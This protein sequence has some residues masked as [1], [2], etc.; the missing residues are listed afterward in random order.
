M[1]YCPVQSQQEACSLYGWSGIWCVLRL[2]SLGDPDVHMFLSL[3][4]Y[5][6]TCLSLFSF[7]LSVHVRVWAF[8]GGEGGGG[9]KYTGVVG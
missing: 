9:A 5:A 2:C 3:C 1:E 7:P 4:I 6:N 8:W